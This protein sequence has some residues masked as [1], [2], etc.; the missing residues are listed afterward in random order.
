MLKYQKQIADIPNCPPTCRSASIVSYRFVFEEIDHQNN[1]LPVL[2]INPKRRLTEASEKCSGYALSFFCSKEKA[3]R[4]YLQL[5]KRNKNI[6]K[7]LGTHIANGFI[8]EADG[9]ITDISKNGHFD[10]YEYE[11]VDLKSKFC[12]VCPI[13][14]E[15]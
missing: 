2:L 7:V 5:K 10:L 14:C 9:L 13:V 3:K 11:N 8:N 15:E 12:I 6:W 1:F 4:R